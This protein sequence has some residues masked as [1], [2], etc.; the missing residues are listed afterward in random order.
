MVIIIPATKGGR[1]ESGGVR[2]REAA[3]CGVVPYAVVDVLLVGDRQSVCR[4]EDALVHARG[5][6][7]P[8]AHAIPCSSRTVARVMFGMFG[9]IF[10]KKRDERDMILYKESLRKTTY[11]I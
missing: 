10:V 6:I 7:C 2:G 4:C 9:K 3:D 5:P 8:A 1:G 11:T